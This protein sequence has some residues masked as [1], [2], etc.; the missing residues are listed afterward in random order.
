[1]RHQAECRMLCVV[2]LSVLSLSVVMLR[3]LSIANP[4]VILK[5]DHMMIVNILT[6]GC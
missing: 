5:K 6:I 4:H 1:M 3:V 2:M